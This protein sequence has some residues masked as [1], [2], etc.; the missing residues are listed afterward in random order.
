MNTSAG[1]RRVSFYGATAKEAA[2]KRTAAIADRN[3]GVPFTDPGRLTVGE[4][5][6]RWLADSAR[7]QVAESTYGRYRRTCSNHLV[8]FFGRV[9][10]RDLSPPHVVRAFKA[11]K[12]EAGLNPNTVGVMQG[13]ISAALSQAVDDG[14]ILLNPASR[15]KKAATR[16][17]SP[18]RPPPGPRRGFE[19][20]TGS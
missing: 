8:P 20:L 19:A 3:R 12:I 17:K 16:S 5:L 11:S 15:V 13:V 6:E 18:M 1:R 7:Y 2:E 10:L 14:L 4:Y 9:K